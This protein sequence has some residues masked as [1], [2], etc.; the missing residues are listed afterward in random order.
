MM[1][2]GHDYLFVAVDRFSK[3]VGLIPYKKTI[4]RGVAR[5]FF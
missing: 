2:W 3:M 1:K 4:I 5:L